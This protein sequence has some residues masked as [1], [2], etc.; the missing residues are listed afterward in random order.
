MAGP[1]NS[2]ERSGRDG[3]ELLAGGPA[4]SS[5][6]RAS[7]LTLRPGGW[8]VAGAEGLPRCGVWLALRTLMV[9]CTCQLDWATVPRSVTINQSR[10]CQEGIF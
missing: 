10:C 1:L 8:M 6:V 4:A 7:G 3:A 9:N 2:Q 5:A